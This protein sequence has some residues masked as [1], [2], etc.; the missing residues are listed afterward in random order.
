MH[1][2]QSIKGPV[3]P[4]TYD[5]WV[6]YIACSKRWARYDCA[7]GKIALEETSHL[8]ITVVDKESDVSPDIIVHQ[9]ILSSLTPASLPLPIPACVGFHEKCRNRYCDICKIKHQEERNKRCIE[10]EVMYN[11]IYS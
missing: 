4:F 6:K 2:N 1:V 3:K 5:S 7:E 10:T 11:S 9:P 8:G